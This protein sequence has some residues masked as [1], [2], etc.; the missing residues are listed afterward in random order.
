MLK[1][2]TTG[3]DPPVRGRN[4]PGM[5]SISALLI[6]Q[7]I[8]DTMITETLMSF[9]NISASMSA[10]KLTLPT[11]LPAAAACSIF[12]VPASHCSQNQR[13]HN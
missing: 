4:Q 1:L 11:V 10:L 12:I 3:I 2:K 8:S 6:S 5:K 13:I 7:L 9:F